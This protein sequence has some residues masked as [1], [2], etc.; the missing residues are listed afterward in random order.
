MQIIGL[1]LNM[2][3]NADVLDHKSRPGYLFSRVVCG[4]SSVRSEGEEHSYGDGCG[5]SCRVIVAVFGLGS[6]GSSAIV[7]LQWSGERVS[8]GDGDGCSSDTEAED[9]QDEAAPGSSNYLAFS[10]QLVAGVHNHVTLSI[11]FSCAMFF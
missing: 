5:V 7:Q 6:E 11:Q 10:R 9:S 8:C 2:S 3:I 4:F 1:F